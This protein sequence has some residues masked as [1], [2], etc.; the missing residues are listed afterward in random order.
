MDIN[1]MYYQFGKY[2]NAKEREKQILHMFS[3]NY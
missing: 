3:K 2:Q 1:F